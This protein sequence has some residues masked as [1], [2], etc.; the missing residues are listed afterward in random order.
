MFV[1]TDGLPSTQR[2]DIV[3]ASIA[4]KRDELYEARPLFVP[5]H[6]PGTRTTGRD[7]LT[8][9]QGRKPRAG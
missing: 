2:L 9:P 4:T 5:A 8:T 7:Q 1:L 3:A 6:G